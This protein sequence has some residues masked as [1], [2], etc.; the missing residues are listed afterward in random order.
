M[1][2]LKVWT[3]FLELINPL[4]YDE[5]GRLFKMMLIYADSGKEPSAI[6]GNERFLWPVAKQQIDLAAEKNEILRR[7]GMKGGRPKQDETKENQ[8]EPDETK[9]NQSKAYKEKKRKEKE[10]NE[11]ESLI[12]D[13]NAREIQTEQ[14]RVLDAAED[15]GFIRSNSVR[16]RLISLYAEHGLEKVLEGIGSC[17]KHGAPNLA[18][19]E[20]VLKGV[21]KKPK[22]K[23]DFPQR[24]YSGVDEELIAQM[25]RDI[26][27]M[28]TG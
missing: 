12:N 15:A 2:Y 1:K 7:N 14:D 25:A 19:L 9:E 10:R 26:E 28:E 23:T 20:A 8:T 22:G 5:I 13:D 3:N 27:A 6:D 16:A 21:Q 4:Q 24:D 11:K 18:Y 17:V